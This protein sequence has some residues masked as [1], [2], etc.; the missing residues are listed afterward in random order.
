VNRVGFGSTRPGQRGSG[1]VEGPKY[2]GK[3]LHNL[4]RKLLGKKRLH[5]TLTNIVIMTY[6]IKSS[7]GVTFSSHEIFFFQYLQIMT[8]NCF[9]LIWIIET[10]LV[11]KKISEARCPPFWHM[12]LDF[13][14]TNLSTLPR[15][16]NGPHFNHEI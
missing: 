7:K 12:H 4:M 9:R 6:D 5:D 10:F 13:S 14:S 1:P 11:V 16:P 2:D 8:I 3:H 15:F